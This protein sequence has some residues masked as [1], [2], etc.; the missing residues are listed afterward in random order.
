MLRGTV[1]GS[2]LGHVLLEVGGVGYRVAVPLGMATG[3]AG[4]EL[5]VHTH[6]AVRE[7]ALTL[8]GFAGAEDRDVFEVLLG[9]TGVGPKVALAGISALGADGVR[10]AV[11]MEDVAALTAI[12]GVGRKGAQR[13]VLELR[14]RLGAG[15]DGDLPAASGTATDPRGEAA[16][17]LAAL[18]YAPAEAQRALD[19]AASGSEASAEDLVRGALRAIARR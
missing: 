9:V 18:G 17:A 2:A 8:Y 14:E 13:M 10:R 5:V 16:Q 3:R 1:A 15:P 11:L 19:A 12:P 6:L 4:E 7:D